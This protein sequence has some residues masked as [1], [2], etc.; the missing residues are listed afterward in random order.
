MTDITPKE[1]AFLDALKNKFETKEGRNGKDKKEEMSGLES[2]VH[3]RLTKEMEKPGEL[4]QETIQKIVDGEINQALNEAHRGTTRTENLVRM[5]T[6]GQLFNRLTGEVNRATSGM[7]GRLVRVLQNGV[8][9]EIASAIDENQEKRI[10]EEINVSEVADMAKNAGLPEKEPEK[11]QKFAPSQPA[12]ATTEAGSVE[13]MIL[14]AAQ[15][16]GNKVLSTAELGELMKDK[17]FIAAANKIA[18]GAKITIR[19]DADDAKDAI[20]IENDDTKKTIRLGDIEKGMR[21]ADD[22]KSG[23]FVAPSSGGQKPVAQQKT[24]GRG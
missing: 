13:A 15:K 18:G 3:Q 9:K 6:T 11:Q 17:N 10:R 24:G 16:D 4:S 21:L 5:S 2:R 1:Q 14:K 22:V 23:E 20:V 8:E 19:N 12:A 7:G